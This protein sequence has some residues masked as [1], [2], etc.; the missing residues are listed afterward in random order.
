MIFSRVIVRIR[1]IWSVR[2]QKSTNFKKDQIV[3]ILGLW[4]TWSELQILDSAIYAWKQSQIIQKQM[5]VTVFQWTFICKN[6][7]PSQGPYLPIITAETS[8][9]TDITYGRKNK[10]MHLNPCNLQIYYTTRQKRI[11]V[12]D[13]NKVANGLLRWHGCKESTCQCRRWKRHGSIP[14]LGRCP[15]LGN[16]NTL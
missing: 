14:G 8:W 9:D 2:E 13:E 4:A 15:G 5:H 1:D 6:K 3:I 11:K 7:Y 10:G 16:G 12:L